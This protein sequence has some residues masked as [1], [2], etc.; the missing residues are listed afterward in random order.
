M[1]IKV[2]L[3]DLAQGL[4]NRSGLA[5]KDS[6]TFVR[7]FFELIEQYLQQD[8]LVK[9]KGLGTFKVV[10]VSG[11]DSVNV[12]TGERI[13]IKGHSKITFTPDATIRDYVNRPFADFE[14]VILNDGVDRA[15]MENVGISSE[16]TL[17]DLPVEDVLPS[18]HVVEDTPPSEEVVE[19]TAPSEDVVEDA[20]PSE[21]VVEDTLPSEDVV[22]DTPPSEEVNSTIIQDLSDMT[23]RAESFSEK[24]G[25]DVTMRPQFFKSDIESIDIVPDHN[26]NE[27]E[28]DSDDLD[29]TLRPGLS[30]DTECI[31]IPESALD[32]HDSSISNSTSDDIEVDLDITHVVE[33]KVISDEVIEDVAKDVEEE[34]TEEIVDEV[35]EETPE[36]IVEEVS[37]EIPVEIVDEVSEEAPEEI[38]EEVSEE[39]PEEIVE[40]VLDKE[41]EEHF[42]EDTV[43]DIAVDEVDD[44]LPSEQVLD[45]QTSQHVV[46]ELPSEVVVESHEDSEDEVKNE[47]RGK[48]SRPRYELRHTVEKQKDSEVEP[49]VVA[50]SHS[51]FSPILLYVLLMIV[52]AFVG[53]YAGS[54]HW[55]DSPCTDETK[56]VNTNVPVTNTLDDE[57]DEVTSVNGSLDDEEAYP[58]EEQVEPDFDDDGFDDEIDNSPVIPSSKKNNSS[59]KNSQDVQIDDAPSKTASKPTAKSDKISD[60][61]AKYPQVNGGQYLI[62][63]VKSV[64]TLKRGESINALARK[65]FGEMEM[66]VY[67]I[68]LNSLSNPDI[69]DV[70]QKIKIPQLERK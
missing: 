27:Q 53:Y 67:I 35:L 10:E 41:T 37:E 66:A 26:L 4:S 13:H 38:V 49:V 59:A 40:E 46:D 15:A 63:G 25:D 42:V 58:Y 51:K 55:F 3:Q 9:I 39:A 14:T 70:G 45:E 64:H 54:H 7:A 61:S 47:P 19:D 29:V 30:P 2:L 65:Y 43:D 50:G 33:D 52:F 23:L 31:D 44:E 22:E 48:F 24:I 34:A 12:N 68:K 36:E 1:D 5:K 60:N 21:D 6:D 11:R 28:E 32:D 17:E 69:V 16:D 62:T 56:V 20:L 18:D 8:K 57:E